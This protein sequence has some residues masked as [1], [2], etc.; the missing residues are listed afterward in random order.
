MKDNILDNDK[1]ISID[2]RGEDKKITEYKSM[3][4]ISYTLYKK[5]MRNYSIETFIMETVDLM[6][7]F[8]DNY[9]EDF[10]IYS[11]NQD[12]RKVIPVEHGCFYKE[13][14]VNIYTYN[15]LIAFDKH[16]IGNMS[17]LYRILNGLLNIQK[18]LFGIDNTPGS[19][20]YNNLKYMEISPDLFKPDYN[21]MLYRS[22]EPNFNLSL[23][24]IGMSAVYKS[25]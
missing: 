17:A 13:T 12:T 24:K 20:D 23:E 22:Y 21:L 4:A 14:S 5:D 25:L 15:I 3:F 10:T 1:I 16:F 2:Y 19:L 7:I 18:H 6:K 8:L 9:L 11:Y